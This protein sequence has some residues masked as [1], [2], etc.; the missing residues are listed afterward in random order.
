MSMNDT[1][2]QLNADLGEGCG[3]DAAIMPF[4]DAANIAC[5]GHAGNADSIEQTIALAIPYSIALGAHPSFPDKAGFGRQ[6]MQLSQS[7]LSDAIGEQL[8]LIERV[9]QSL[10]VQLS[11][12]KPHGALYNQASSDSQLADQ[13]LDIFAEFNPMLSV[14]GLAGG[15]LVKRGAARGLATLSEGFADRRYQANGQLAARGQ[16]HAVIENPAE[17]IAQVNQ[18]LRSGTVTAI[19]NSTVTLLCDT[20]CLHGDG[21]KAIEFAQQVAQIVKS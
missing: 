20:L 4:I 8:Q 19:D 1:R 7:E 3:N 21:A 13:L 18:I 15:E 17:A 6:N 11:H 14:V 9:A 2:L 10:G 12:I 5:G 16:P